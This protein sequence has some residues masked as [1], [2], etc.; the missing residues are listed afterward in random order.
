M[1]MPEIPQVSLDDVP[2][3]PKKPCSWTQPRI[4]G[5]VSTPHGFLGSRGTHRPGT[6][7]YWLWEASLTPMELTNLARTTFS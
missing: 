4:I 5:P 7:S 2:R 1:I 3:L 6:I